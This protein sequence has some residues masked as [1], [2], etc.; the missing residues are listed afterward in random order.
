MRVWWWCEEN[1]SSKLL[2]ALPTLQ[3]SAEIL[4]DPPT[5]PQSKLCPLNT[6]YRIMVVDDSRDFRCFRVV[7][8]FQRENPEDGTHVQYV[9]LP[10]VLPTGIPVLPTVGAELKTDGGYV[11][12]KNNVGLLAF[13][14][15]AA[16][17]KCKH[18]AWSVL[19]DD[20]ITTAAYHAGLLRPVAD[21]LLHSKAV[22]T[23]MRPAHVMAATDT[24]V[25]IK[26]APRFMFHGTYR[27]ASACHYL[28][29]L[30]PAAA[31]LATT[32]PTRAPRT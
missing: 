26:R 27:Q 3:R 13:R 19:D 32:P 23:F 9:G 6:N 17:T 8:R 11:S 14:E 20:D 1:L 7:S 25:V 15:W 24:G 30:I 5:T 12:A 21:G 31:N 16:Q 28:L 10:K 4:H 18:L 22:I 29:S 2:L